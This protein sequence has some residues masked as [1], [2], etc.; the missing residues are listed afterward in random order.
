M[1]WTFG[2]AERRR[3]IRDDCI[4]TVVES[5]ETEKEGKRCLGQAC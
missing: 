4:V 5:R 1:I 3:G 2:M